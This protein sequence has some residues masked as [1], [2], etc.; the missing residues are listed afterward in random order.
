MLGALGQEAVKLAGKDKARAP[1]GLHRG[2]RG[3]DASIERGETDAEG[4]RSLLA[5]VG[6]ALDGRADLGVDDVRRPARF[7]GVT[8]HLRASAGPG[9]TVS[10]DGGRKRH[11]LGVPLRSGVM[12]ARAAERP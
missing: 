5:R 12:D 9:R 10:G 6:E 8:E 2:N 4:F 7:G 11:R 1:L 3:H